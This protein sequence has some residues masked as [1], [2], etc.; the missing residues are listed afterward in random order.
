MAIGLA[1]AI[2]LGQKQP[3]TKGG[4][5][6]FKPWK[7][8]KGLEAGK[9]LTPEQIAAAA[10][11]LTTLETRPEIRGYRQI[12]NQLRNEKQREA[13]G[14]TALG[15]RNANEVAGVYKNIAQSAAQSLATE[16]ALGGSLAGQSAAL[17]QQGAQQLGAESKAAV[18]PLTQQLQM[19]G[20]EGTAGTAQAQ[21]AQAVAAQQTAGAQ[22]GAA[23]QQAALGQA[24]NYSGLLAGMAGATQA[25]GGEAIGQIARTAANRVGESNAKYDTNIQTA[26]GKLGEAKATRGEKLVKNLLGIEEQQQKFKTAEQAVAGN[27]TKL[28]LEAAEGQKER[29]ENQAERAEKRAERSEQSTRENRKERRENKELENETAKTEA[30]VGKKKK[31]HKQEVAE[32]KSLI[33]PVVSGLGKPPANVP[34]NKVLNK[35]I[36]EIN[37][38]ASADPRV[39]AEVVKNW[40]RQKLQREQVEEAGKAVTPFP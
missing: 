29:E 19:R 37:S 39:V 26:L 15:R 25:R 27:K 9:L 28:A 34:P 31:E 32:V 38:K 40:W 10:H 13:K 24:G 4:S 14:L 21:L 16:N 12:T 3:K 6:G 8:L 36:A 23:A 11:A 30:T 17:A 22:Q 33:G 5:P 7:V 35:Y 20:A 18:E 2:A 1:N